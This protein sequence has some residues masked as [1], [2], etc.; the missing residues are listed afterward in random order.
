MKS[1]IWTAEDVRRPSPELGNP[2]IQ[3][4]RKRGWAAGEL[5]EVNGRPVV[6]WNGE[7]IVHLGVLSQWSRYGVLRDVKQVGILLDD[8]INPPK[9]VAITDPRRVIEFCASLNW[10][11][12]VVVE[13]W[14]STPDAARIAGVKDRRLKRGYTK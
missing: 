5:K 10:E 2:A 14:H 4:W 1:R 7:E 8:G 13:S 9:P 11:V 6:V 3:D 12:G